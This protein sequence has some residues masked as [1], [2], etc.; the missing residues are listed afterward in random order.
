MTMIKMLS[1][2]LVAEQPNNVE[3]HHSMSVD[4]KN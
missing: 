1:M 4:V 3:G 2:G